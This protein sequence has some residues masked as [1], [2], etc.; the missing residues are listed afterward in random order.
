[1]ANEFASAGQGVLGGAGTGAMIGSAF[2]PIGIG[3][4]AILGGIVGGISGAKKASDVNEGL[5]ALM[6]VPNVDPMQLA[7]KDQ[8]LKEKRAVEG[9]F[10]T[11]FQVARDIISKSEAGGM[12]VAAEM[13]R[14]KSV[15]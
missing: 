7:F 14:R 15:V 13:A 8:L 1:M 11:D 10:T 12:S 5:N 6:M 3:V 2:G 9:G 4:G